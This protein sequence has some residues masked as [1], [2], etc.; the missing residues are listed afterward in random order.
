LAFAGT[1]A[2][3]RTLS[4]HPLLVVLPLGLWLFSFVCD[5]IYVWRRAPVWRE[6]AFYDIVGGIA[7]A[8]RT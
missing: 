4:V 1:L 5:L 2:R 3:L 6:V 7:G 8:A